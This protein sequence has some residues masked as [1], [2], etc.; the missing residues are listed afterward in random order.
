[1]ELGGNPINNS[2]IKLE[3]GLIA[4]MLGYFLRCEPQIAEVIL[5]VFRLDDLCELVMQPKRDD[6]DLMESIG[7]LYILCLY[8]ACTSDL[9]NIPFKVLSKVIYTIESCFS[10]SVTYMAENDLIYLTSP[11]SKVIHLRKVFQD[12]QGLKFLNFSKSLELAKEIL[13]DMIKL[14]RNCREKV[15]IRT[16]K[17]KKKFISDCFQPHT[18]YFICIIALSHIFELNTDEEEAEI[19]NLPGIVECILL[20]FVIEENMSYKTDL[21][22]TTTTTN[23]NSIYSLKSDDKEKLRIDRCLLFSTELA[24]SVLDKKS[25]THIKAISTFRSK[26][27]REDINPMNDYCRMQVNLFKTLVENNRKKK[28]NNDDEGLLKRKSKNNY[29]KTI[30][31]SGRNIS[32]LVFKQL[33]ENADDVNI[34][35]VSNTINKDEFD[36]YKAI[37]PRVQNCYI[38]FKMFQCKSV[39]KPKK[40]IKK[41]KN[42]PDN[43]TNFTKAVDQMTN[44]FSELA[45]YPILPRILDSTEGQYWCCSYLLELVL[46]NELTGQFL[47]RPS[48]SELVT[49]KEDL[50]KIKIN[51]EV[52]DEVSNILMGPSA[53]E[54]VKICLNNRPLGSQASMHSSSTVNINPNKKNLNLFEKLKLAAAEAKTQSKLESI[55]ESEARKKRLNRIKSNRVHASTN[56]LNTKNTNS[57]DRGCP[58]VSKLWRDAPP[59]SKDRTLL[60]F[61]QNSSAFDFKITPEASKQYAE[62]LVSIKEQEAKLEEKKRQDFEMLQELEVGKTKTFKLIRLRTSLENRRAEQEDSLEIKKYSDEA[63]KE[64]ISME[65]AKRKEERK[66]IKALE[67]KELFRKKQLD[68]KERYFQETMEREKKEREEFE[69]VRLKNMA[70]KK[71]F[72]EIIRRNEEESRMKLL[73]E[74]QNLRERSYF[75]LEKLKSDKIKEKQDTVAKKVSRNTALV[76]K[77]VFKWVRGKYTFYPEARMHE[78]PWI[79]YEDENGVP[80]YYDSITHKTQYKVPDDAPILDHVNVEI[81]EYEKVH[82]VGSFAAMIAEREW[83]DQCNANGGYYDDRGKWVT[84]RG[85]W[86]ENYEWVDL[87][88]GY[89]NDKGEFILHPPVSGN[90]DFM[91]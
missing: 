2:N 53:S 13:R 84:N 27:S 30:F 69:R 62:K 47:C 25:H 8:M 71:E 35:K 67:E 20:A 60:A 4:D 59:P 80:Y 40:D 57:I 38:I 66:K 24:F 17:T 33:Y 49:L 63:K 70:D 18:I 23:S 29:A 77:G 58:K 21:T 16:F 64:L 43:K 39:S 26:N 78:V 31:L 79:Q 12:V 75:R 89:Y 76:R 7:S 65:K 11:Y 88:H 48:N 1:M 50:S 5:P 51:K 91:V 14:V 34:S 55:N 3:S 22:S 32:S 85:Y 82:G 54:I 83:K 61:A 86:D 68:S 15:D 9:N 72:N 90:L 46:L 52:P 6:G 28:L 41:A 74:R 44:Y 10:E 36:I 37:H 81:D 87:S 56:Q 73:E 42:T 19:L 45:S